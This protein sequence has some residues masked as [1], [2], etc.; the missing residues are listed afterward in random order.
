M[1]TKVT[2][3][4]VKLIYFDSVLCGDSYLILLFGID[5]LFILLFTKQ[6]FIFPKIY[7]VYFT[8]H[9]QTRLSNHLILVIVTYL[10]FT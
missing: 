8:T 1:D 7:I 10:K 3:K 4:K 2:Q 9:R 5:C 6:I